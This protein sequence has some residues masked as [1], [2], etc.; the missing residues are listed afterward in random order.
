MIK[1]KLIQLYN[2]YIVLY[3][4]HITENINYENHF[5]FYKDEE[6]AENLVNSLISRIAAKDFM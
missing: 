6:L 3:K 4:R 5:A 1:L 2:M